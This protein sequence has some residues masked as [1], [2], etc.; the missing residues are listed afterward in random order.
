MSHIRV[1]NHEFVMNVAMIMIQPRNGYKYNQYYFALDG[2][3]F[4]AK[5]TRQRP[6]HRLRI[7]DFCIL[8]KI[9]KNSRILR[10]RKSS[11]WHKNSNHKFSNLFRG[12]CRVGRLAVDDSCSDTEEHNDIPPNDP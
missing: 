7:R 6:G 11:C 8:F 1:L 3:F 9:R 4:D 2:T 12:N 10:N 5:L